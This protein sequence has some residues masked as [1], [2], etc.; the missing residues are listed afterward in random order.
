M[1]GIPLTAVGGDAVAVPGLTSPYTSPNDLLVGIESAQAVGLG[2]TGTIPELSCFPAFPDVHS[3]T[4][5]P[6]VP[7]VKYSLLN[8][9]G[10][11]S[12]VQQTLAG[13]P[14]TTGCPNPPFGSGLGGPPPF[15]RGAAKNV[16]SVPL[17][18]AGRPTDGITGAQASDA[19]IIVRSGTRV[20][21]HGRTLASVPF[22]GSAK[23]SVIQNA[24]CHGA[25]RATPNRA[26]LLLTDAPQ[27]VTLRVKAGRIYVHV[28]GSP[29]HGQLEVA[30]KHG[31]RFVAW[32]LDRRQSLRVA[33]TGQLL[34]L[35]IRLAER[36][37]RWAVA[38][39][40]LPV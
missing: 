27:S 39:V 35:R 6:Y 29:N 26:V 12:D 8:D 1:N 40:T 11:A 19:A 4:F 14:P 23:I 9:P 31:R 34:T 13:N 20:T 25:L 21:C 30:I 15:I 22:M 17:R 36:G 10:V 37:G 2:A 5:L 7:S 38:V 33:A 28:Q 18:V 16:I 32:A 3:N 24:A